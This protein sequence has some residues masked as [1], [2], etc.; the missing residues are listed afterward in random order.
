MN[1]PG[2]RL[3]NEWIIFAFLHCIVNSGQEAKDDKK[4]KFK[5]IIVTK[6]DEKRLLWSR[7]WEHF[8]PAVLVSTTR[9]T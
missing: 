2:R 8:Q 3:F 1:G 6:T 7:F 5:C 4:N 9:G